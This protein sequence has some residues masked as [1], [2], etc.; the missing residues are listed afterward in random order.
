MYPGAGCPPNDENP[1]PIGV[2]LATELR[3]CAEVETRGVVATVDRA[4]GPHSSSTTTPLANTVVDEAALD[5]EVEVA[6]P[7]LTVAEVLVEIWWNWCP[8]PEP[9]RAVSEAS[10]SRW[11]AVGV[12]NREKV[13]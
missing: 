8:T 6:A 3:A 7:V 10:A 11:V 4:S 13:S 5:E 2:V 1:S 12:A 9:L